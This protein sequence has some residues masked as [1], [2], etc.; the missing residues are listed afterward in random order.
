MPPEEN[1]NPP[2]SQATR[3][4][5]AGYN[6]PEE[7][8]RGYLASSEEAKRQKARADANEQRAQQLEQL[9]SSRQD[10]TQRP[11]DPFQ[12]L[13]DYGVPPEDL[14][15]AIDSRLKQAFEPIVRAGQA[16]NEV[17]AQYPDYTKYESDVARFVSGDA[18]L[19]ERYQRMFTADPAAAMEYAFMKF[20][21]TQRKTHKSADEPRQREQ[22]EAQIP[23]SRS[24]DSRQVDD[25]GDTLR[26]AWSEF[27][28]TGNPAARDRYIKARLRTAIKD[29]F[30]ER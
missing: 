19:N 26:N 17:L 14:Q 7:L 18:A 8:E 30:F 1:G 5:W 13:R 28:K 10:L 4:N 20:G 21:E 11:A 25:Q 27:Q 23:S 22:A 2:E 3:R 6:S 24:G 16:R 29:E 15:E 9:M 12:R